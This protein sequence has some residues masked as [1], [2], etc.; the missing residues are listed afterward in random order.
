MVVDGKVELIPA[1]DVGGI[2]TAGSDERCKDFHATLVAIIPPNNLG[3]INM[4]HVIGF[5]ARLRTGIAGNTQEAVI[6]SVLKRMALSHRL[7]FPRP[8]VYN[9]A[10][11]RGAG[12]E[13]IVR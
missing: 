8:P 5:Q 4:V 7:T 10:R 13:E 11:K 1:V 3:Q 2:V 6:E 12:R 9:Q